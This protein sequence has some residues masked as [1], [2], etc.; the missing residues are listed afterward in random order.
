VVEIA[1]VIGDDFEDSELVVPR[2]RL[3]GEGHRVT[4]VGAR[5]GA[6]V[7]GKHGTEVAVDVAAADADPAR[8][9]AVVVPGGWSPDRL[10]TVPEVA[11]LVGAVGRH[12]GLVAAICHG[13]SLLID[14]DLVTGRTVTSWPSIRRDLEHAGAVWT[15]DE[16]VVDGRLVTSR[17]PSDLDAFVRAICQGLD[18]T[19]GPEVGRGP[20]LSV[21]DVH[22]V[23]NYATFPRRLVRG[24][25]V[26]VHDADGRRYLDM[27]AAYSALSFGHRHPR[28]V[29]AARAQLG[30]LTLTSRAFANDQLGPFCDALAALSAKDAVL[31][32]NTG[33][34]AVETAIKAARRWGYR[35][36]GVPADSA[37]IVVFADNFHGRTTTI[38]GFSSNP[39]ARRDFGPFTPGF[40]TVP[41][42]DLDAVAAAIDETTV[43]VLVE[44]IQG[45]AGIIVPPEGFLGG[46]RRL[47]TDHRV[48]LVADEVQSGLGR[49]GRRF[50]CDHE[51]VVPDLY[52]LGKPLGGGIVPIS[53]VV[54][55]REVLGLFDP[56]SHGS[57][58]G[59]NPF[60]CAIGR[61]V[62]ELL[63]DGT[64]V[65]HAALLGEHLHHRLA[66]LPSEW[67]R[68]VRGRGLWAG[69][70]LAPDLPPG[71]RVCEI[72]HDHGLLVVATRERTLRI[73]PPLVIEPDELDWGLDRLADGLRV[74][75]GER[76]R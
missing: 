62:I 6:T 68:S 45:E 21:E 70:D 65:E 33:A 36:K 71:R 10:R 19:S 61:A 23:G 32:M 1:F 22:L 74:A 37:T 11:A 38:V 28:L 57:T 63:A 39:D 44:P 7:R 31:P 18:A 75:A 56:G 60:A 13:P 5:A 15:D 59:G 14:A 29:A 58:F 24:D 27:F 55:D 9:A 69:L 35:T 42:G 50:A 54:G 66:A 49:T 34:E 16:V 8:F 26:W 52:L 30:R 2:D 25:G 53:A 47:C 72:L 46:L 40:R 20:D 43:A 51:G 4:M 64:V 67:V 12:G 3:R 41:F 73:A 48:L 17:R 76:A